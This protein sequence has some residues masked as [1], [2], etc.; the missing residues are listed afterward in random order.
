MVITSDVELA[1][2]RESASG[3]IVEF[4]PCAQTGEPDPAC[5][6]HFAVRQ[7]GRSVRRTVRYHGTGVC[8][9]PA[10]RVVEFRAG[11]LCEASAL[12]TCDEHL[13]VC[14]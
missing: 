12:S 8:P 10:C 11:E 4:G 6:E 5:N 1:R 14:K 9:S 13:P 7:Q 3:R 2:V